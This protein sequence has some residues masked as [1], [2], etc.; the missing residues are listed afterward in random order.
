MGLAALVPESAIVPYLWAQQRN[1]Q[2]S[3]ARDSQQFLLGGWSFLHCTFPCLHPFAFSHR[4]KPG[5]SNPPCAYFFIQFPSMVLISWPQRLTQLWTCWTCQLY[6]RKHPSLALLN[7]GCASQLALTWHQPNT[8]LGDLGKLPLSSL[9]RS[10]W[11]KVCVSSVPMYTAVCVTRA[12]DES[13]RD[14]HTR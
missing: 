12:K 6:L 7:A 5:S 10:G 4:E 1:S 11:G 2:L 9:K 14:W 8:N 3:K 13:G